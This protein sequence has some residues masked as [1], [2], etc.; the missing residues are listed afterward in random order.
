MTRGLV[1]ALVILPLA[2]YGSSQKIDP[3]SQFGANP[4]LPEPHEQLVA[5]VGVFETVGWQCGE[6]PAVPV[7][8][9]I[10]ALAQGLSNPRNVLA[11]SNGDVLIVKSRNEG[12]ES[13]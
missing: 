3:N 10:A 8:F 2:A 5:D 4:V 7:G 1:A 6:T 9:Q 12:G 11:L 13:I